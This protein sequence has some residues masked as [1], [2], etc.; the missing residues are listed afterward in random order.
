M[1]LFFLSAHFSRLVYALST[2]GG[3]KRKL[4]VA[5][6]EKGNRYSTAFMAIRLA[7]GAMVM[8]RRRLLQ[9]SLRTY[10]NLANQKRRPLQS[11]GSSRKWCERMHGLSH[12]RRLSDQL[13]DRSSVPIETEHRAVSSG[14]S[15][16]SLR[17]EKNMV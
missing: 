3:K 15:L 12:G 16:L 14:I 13:L 4:R 17:M 2:W 1:C 9:K 6:R 10:P 8:M 5:T 11:L 7:A